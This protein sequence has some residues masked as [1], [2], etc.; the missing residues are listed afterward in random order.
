MAD[1]N[2]S[3]SSFPL[4]PMQY[5]DNYE[6][7]DKSKHPVPPPP[8]NDE[9]FEMFGQTIHPLESIENLVPSL[10]RENIK[11]IVKLDPNSSPI[12]EMKSINVSLVTKFLDLL[13]I[14]TK[15]PDSSES[16][17]VYE[18]LKNLFQNI[19]YLVNCYRPHQA[20]ETLI[21]LMQSQEKSRSQTIEQLEKLIAV[22]KNFKSAVVTDLKKVEVGEDPVISS[23]SSAVKKEIDY[24]YVASPGPDLSTININ[25][26]LM[27]EL[28]L[29][30]L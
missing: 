11:Q 16:E 17:I 28:L 19:H 29:N 30:K 24:E 6:S 22:V 10:E 5:I 26:E 8:I 21:T 18:E 9:P 2:Y 13:D 20:R 15:N 12:F 4:P 3:S 27:Q 23:E 14:L 25:D 7:E 1:Q